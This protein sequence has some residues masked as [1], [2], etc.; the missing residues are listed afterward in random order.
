MPRTKTNATPT[1]TPP[2]DQVTIIGRLTADPQLRFTPK[3]TPVSRMRMAVN[4][5]PSPTFHTVVCWGRTADVVCQYLKKGRPVE[6][7]GRFRERSYVAKDGSEHSVTEVYA[8][9]VGFLS[10]GQLTS[11]HA[12]VAS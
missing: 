7:S 12:D 5:G 1:A 2:Q 11:A 9:R 6:V 10:R 3:G 4:D 8:W